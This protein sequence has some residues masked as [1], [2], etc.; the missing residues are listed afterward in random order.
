MTRIQQLNHSPYLSYGF[1]TQYFVQF[2]WY[3]TNKSR[4][5]QEV[6]APKGLDPPLPITTNQQNC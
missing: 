5:R 6:M 2:Q 1:I 3:Y 4:S